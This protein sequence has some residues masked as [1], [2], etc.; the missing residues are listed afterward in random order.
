MKAF[1]LEESVGYISAL[2]GRIRTSA[3]TTQQLTFAA[4]RSGINF[5]AL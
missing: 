2:L 5:V 1:F 3:V 4:I